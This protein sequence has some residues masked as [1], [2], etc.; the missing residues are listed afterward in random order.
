MKKSMHFDNP[1]VVYVDNVAD[2]PAA[3]DSTQYIAYRW[4]DASNV[5]VTAPNTIT[6]CAIQKVINYSTGDVSI[7]WANGDTEMNKRFSDR[8]TLTYYALKSGS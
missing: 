8:T 3:G 5:D 7:G 2:S 1:P 6:N 4:A